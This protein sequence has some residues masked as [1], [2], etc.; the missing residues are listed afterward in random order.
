MCLLGNDVISQNSNINTNNNNNNNNANIDSLMSR[1]LNAFAGGI[2]DHTEF[3]NLCQ[4]YHGVR[5]VF[6]LTGISC[7]RS[8]SGTMSINSND[9]ELKHKVESLLKQYCRKHAIPTFNKNCKEIAGTVYLTNDNYKKLDTDLENIELLFYNKPIGVLH[10]ELL[11]IFCFV[12]IFVYFNFVCTIQIVAKVCVRVNSKNNSKFN[13][14]SICHKSLKK[15]HRLLQP[16][17]KRL[18]LSV[19]CFFFLNQ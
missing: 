6:D 14:F 18:L 11:S 9:R 3:F 10:T 15:V 1:M 16:P 4:M 13:L 12:F 7:S 17:C 8:G 5:I 2:C 19:S